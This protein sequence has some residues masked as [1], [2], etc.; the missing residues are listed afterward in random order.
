LYFVQFGCLTVPHI[1][2]VTRKLSVAVSLLRFFV[3]HFNDNFLHVEK[4]FKELK[5]IYPDTIF[6]LYDIKE[7]LF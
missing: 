2:Q 4:V 5:E 3:R 7:R 1:L 6:R